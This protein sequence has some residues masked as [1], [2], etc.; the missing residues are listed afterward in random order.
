MRVSIQKKHYDYREYQTYKTFLIQTDEETT[1]VSWTS[2]LCT[3][4]P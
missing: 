1:K 3:I 4:A 2:C